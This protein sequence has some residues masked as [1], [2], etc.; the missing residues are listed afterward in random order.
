[1]RNIQL[2]LNTVVVHF[3]VCIDQPDVCDVR[4]YFL[5][6]SFQIHFAEHLQKH[7]KLVKVKMDDGIKASNETL[8]G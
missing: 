5:I 6:Y 4:E 1:M 3:V 2:I 7:S 8:A